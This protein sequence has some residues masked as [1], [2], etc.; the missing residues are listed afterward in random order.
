MYTGPPDSRSVL[1]PLC[2]VTWKHGC[3][4]MALCLCPSHLISIPTPCLEC[5]HES[6]HVLMSTQLPI[7]AQPP[8]DSYMETWVLVCGSVCVAPSHPACHPTP[9]LKY[10][11]PSVHVYMSISPCLLHP[12]RIVIRK[13][14][15]PCVAVCVS[16]TPIF[17]HTLVR[18]CTCISTGIYVHLTPHVC[19]TPLY[20]FIQTWVTLCV[21]SNQSICNP[22]P[23]LA[24][25]FASVHVLISTW[26]PMSAPSP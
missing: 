4:C 23:S 8:M 24:C 18:M 14:G 5:V 22:T 11:H 19:S 1:K 15:C 9:W 16:M 10:V 12:L 3:S 13:P 7:L 6:V 26:L 2:I 20:S 17:S 21:C 25:I